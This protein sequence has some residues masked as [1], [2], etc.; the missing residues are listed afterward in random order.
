MPGCHH[1]QH[2]RMSLGGGEWGSRGS[3]LRER[4]PGIQ[5]DLSHP[6]TWAV[7][8]AGKGR[9]GEGR[10]RASLTHAERCGRGECWG[11]QPVI[12]QPSEAS[13][14][15]LNRPSY[16]SPHGAPRQALDRPP[17]PLGPYPLIGGITGGVDLE[18]PKRGPAHFVAGLRARIGVARHRRWR[19]KTSTGCAQ[20]FLEGYLVNSTRACAHSE[21]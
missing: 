1:R 12:P 11:V 4:S 9:T 10:D 6:R 14:S 8:P 16:C 2:V 21:D 18:G 19:S 5:P 20:C 15:G 17:M 13:G 3:S 7:L